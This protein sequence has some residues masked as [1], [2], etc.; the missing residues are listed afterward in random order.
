MNSWFDDLLHTFATNIGAGRLEK[1]EA[2]TAGLLF[3]NGDH[4]YLEENEQVVQLSLVRKSSGFELLRE[5]EALL[6]LCHF[7]HSRM[8]QAQPAL[9]GEDV[10]VLGISLPQEDT[11]FDGLNHA[12][13]QLQDM[14]NQAVGD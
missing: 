5:I 1:S 13:I 3:E 10:L 9:L 6:N 4:L 7:R 2:G 12:V 8:Y 14:M 11:T